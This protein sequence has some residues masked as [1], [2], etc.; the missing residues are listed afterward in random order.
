MNERDDT[1]PPT[2]SRGLTRRLPAGVIDASLASLATF[3]AGLT[4][5]NVFGDVDRGVY[6]VFFTSFMLGVVLA[7]NLVYVPASVE[8]VALPV[9]DR[10][11]HLG[12]S[13]RLGLIPALLGSVAVVFAV[14]VTSSLT[15][16]GVVTGL[17]ISTAIA[18]VLSPIQDHVR[19]MLHIAEQSWRA[20]A[21]SAVQFGGVAVS[22]ATMLALDIE[23]AWLPFGTLA[24]AN[25]ASLT[26]GLLL[27]RRSMR[28]R[29]LG[30]LRF[31]ALA[32]QGRWLL[33][34]STIPSLA[35]F[36]VAAIITKL[37]GP[38][39]M[40]FAEAARVVA[41][42]VLVFATGLT[43]VLAPQSMQAAMEQDAPGGRRVNRLY[44]VLILAAGA[45]Y[46]LAAGRPW[47][48]NPMQHLVP[49]AYVVGWLAAVTI[50]SN[51]IGAAMYLDINELLGARKA[52]WLAGIAIATS[53]IL[54]AVALTS[55]ATGA[56]ARPYGLM[57][58]DVVQ[59]AWYRA[60][61]RRHYDS[62]PHGVGARG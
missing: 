51:L 4:A 31:G 32:R 34:E 6:A 37:A 53:P 62:A 57:A 44:T 11:A 58:R 27:A 24:I 12:R 1:K 60:A 2:R 56:F 29:D 40:G 61:L 14:L 16:Q 45:A 33:A 13:V 15:D 8:A 50:V 3:L 26:A 18:T 22:L 30:T 19:R 49:A 9:P 55:R 52:R 41:Q 21:V 28:T 46:L 10:L 36:G 54:I 7:T 20:A 59:I 42:P 48:W 39:A 47:V 25:A 35:H 43:A 17:A 5:V 38:E 23:R